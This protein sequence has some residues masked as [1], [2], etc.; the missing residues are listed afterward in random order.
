MKEN[1]T[2]QENAQQE[3]EAQNLQD[4]KLESKQDITSQDSSLKG[5]KEGKLDTNKLLQVAEL[6]I[7]F[8]GKALGLLGKA[9]GNLYNH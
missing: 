2:N 7:H 3:Q 1:N 9:L 6:G 5:K 4:S 8:L